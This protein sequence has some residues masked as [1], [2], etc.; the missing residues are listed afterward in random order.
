MKMKRAV[1]RS[2]LQESDGSL[3]RN[4]GYAS[5]FLIGNLSV[6][7]ARTPSAYRHSTSVRWS[8]AT[9][10]QIRHT[11]RRH[12]NDNRVN[13][14]RPK[15]LGRLMKRRPSGRAADARIDRLNLWGIFGTGAHGCRATCSGRRP[16]PMGTSTLHRSRMRT[17]STRRS[18]NRKARGVSSA[19]YPS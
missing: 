1:K 12:G 13:P 16:C 2:R 15:R 18:P 17:T 10:T 8:K 14:Y 11:G 4:I 9:M 6:F 5:T 3:I 19:L 7:P